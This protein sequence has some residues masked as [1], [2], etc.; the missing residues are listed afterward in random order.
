MQRCRRNA[1]QTE[2]C[3]EVW[4]ELAWQT[5]GMVKSRMVRAVLA[6]T[7]STR[8]APAEWIV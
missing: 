5:Q 4:P 3:K 1:T 8:E 7:V 2:E 6:T